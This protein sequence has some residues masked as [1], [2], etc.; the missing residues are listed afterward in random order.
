MERKGK[1]CGREFEIIPCIQLNAADWLERN[2]VRNWAKNPEN[3]V[4]VLFC[5]DIFTVWDHGEGP[6]SIGSSPESAMPEWLYNELDRILA[7]QDLEYAI[8]RLMNVENG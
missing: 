1:S 4:A 7:D 2:D 3:G 6:H 8:I 5:D